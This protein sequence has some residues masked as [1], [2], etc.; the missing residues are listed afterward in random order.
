[1]AEA[2]DR[3][4]TIESGFDLACLTEARHLFEH[5]AMEERKR[6]NRAFVENLTVDGV[7]GCGEL[8]TKRIPDAQSIRDSFKVV[9]GT[10]CEVQQRD[11]AREIE[12][13]PLRFVAEGTGL[14]LVGV[15]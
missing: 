5:G 14:V 1:M 12:V 8:R 13:I 10:R 9:A 3:T 15:G 11:G 2:A 6:V 4:T 7:G